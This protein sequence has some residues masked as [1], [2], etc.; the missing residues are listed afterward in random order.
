MKKGFFVLLFILATA[1]CATTTRRAVTPTDGYTP[2]R[3]NDPPRCI[4][5]ETFEADGWGKHETKHFDTYCLE[6]K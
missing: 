5:V 4:V 1:G 6:K 3:P 2:E